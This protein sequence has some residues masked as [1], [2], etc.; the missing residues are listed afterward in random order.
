MF[1]SSCVEV[2]GT[3]AYIRVLCMYLFGSSENIMSKS[4]GKK[5]K[6]MH[7]ALQ[8]D[9]YVSIKILFCF[10][11][12]IFFNSTKSIVLTKDDMFQNLAIFKQE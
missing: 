4:S 10:N 7:Y 5:L 11:S 2:K 3:D 9:Y 6:K 1:N 12:R 8:R